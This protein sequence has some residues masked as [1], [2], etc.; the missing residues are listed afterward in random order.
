MKI[1]G[2]EHIESLIKQ[3]ESTNVSRAKGEFDKILN[4]KMDGVNKSVESPAGRP[5]DRL[6]R[7]SAVL[8]RSAVD[9][10]EV[11]SRVAEFLDTVEEYSEKLKRPEVSLKEIYPLISKIKKDTQDLTSLSQSLSPDDEI[12]SLLD[13]ALVRSTVEVIKFN[14]GD[15]VN[16]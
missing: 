6:N 8:L 16:P 5:V 13:E 10:R 12:K 9:K 1:T 3:K 15:Y 2:S 7:T 14:R 4:E 11:V